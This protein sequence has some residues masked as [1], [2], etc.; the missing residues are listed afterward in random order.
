[1][2]I[3]AR[4]FEQLEAV[5]SCT[6]SVAVN[7]IDHASFIMEQ[8]PDGAPPDTWRAIIPSQGLEPGTIRI[9]H[10]L[11]CPAVAGEKR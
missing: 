1:M 5:S 7:L 11:E 8:G 4:V 9:R 2:A 3:H 6:L 10:T